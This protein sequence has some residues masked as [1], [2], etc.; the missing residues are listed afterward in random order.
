MKLQ[1]YESFEYNLTV[2]DLMCLLINYNT[3]VGTV[4]KLFMDDTLGTS[5]SDCESPVESP[6]MLP[7]GHL[8][9][10]SLHQSSYEL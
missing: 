6:Q 7:L 10:R 3:C 1:N 8:L 5:Y 9:P 4:I 2:S